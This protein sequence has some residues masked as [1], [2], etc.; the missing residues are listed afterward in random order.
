[1][2][3]KGTVCSK[4]NLRNP[5]TICLQLV[6]VADRGGS[7]TRW[8]LTRGPHRLGPFRR[9]LSQIKAIPWIVR[10]IGRSVASVP[11]LVI[12]VNSVFAATTTPPF[13]L[14]KSAQILPVFAFLHYS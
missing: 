4:V 5:S 1:M 13:F 7:P 9:R 10:L 6:K 11:K 12:I 14:L 8:S 3:N 2:R